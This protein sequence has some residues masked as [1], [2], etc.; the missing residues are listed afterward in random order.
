[1][2]VMLRHLLLFIARHL[3]LFVACAVIEEELLSMV[4]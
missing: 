3:S 4:E 1:M 2:D